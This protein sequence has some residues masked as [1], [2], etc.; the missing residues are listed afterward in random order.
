MWRSLLAG[1]CSTCLLAGCTGGE[2]SVRA[3][4]LV[5]CSEGSPDSFN[6]QI[7]TSGT[8]YDASAHTLYDRL[9]A[10]DPDTGT[11]LPALALSWTVSRDGTRWR[12]KLRP[13]VQFHHTAW[14]SPSRPFNADDIVFSFERQWRK[15][16]PYHR[17]SGGVY[18]YFENTGLHRLLAAIVKRSDDEVEFQLTESNAT[19]LSMLS[20]EF[21]SILSAEYAAQLL[22]AGKPEQLDQ[23][24]IGTGPFRLQRYD[25][26]AFIRYEAHPDYYAG[27][28]KVKRLVFAITPD[29]S[30]RLS[31]LR[32]GEC[33]VMSQPSPAHLTLIRQNPAL[34]L[35]SQPA[36][37]VSYWAFN[38]RRPPLN[39]ARV[40]QALA[41]A[42]NRSAILDAVYFGAGEIAKSPVPPTVPGHD[43]ELTDFRHD[44]ARA[45][46]LLA[47]AGY[48]DG[49]SLDV[50]AMPVSRPYN[51]NARKMAELIQDDLRQI[52]VNVRIV[53]YE[54]RDFLRRLRLGEH[55]SVLLGWSGDLNDADNFLSPLLTCAA[56]RAGSNRALWCDDMFDGLL[57]RA[58]TTR[59][60]DHRARLYS[61]ALH[62]F[63][64]QTPWLTL[65]HSTQYLAARQSIVGLRQSASGGV[66]FHQAERRK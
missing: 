48:A 21:A 24:P 62:I 39:D 47:E 29:V 30:L 27:A 11:A 34:R 26:G 12:F 28:A 37:N 8:A 46:E 53:S 19:F 32:A 14:F 1:F 5:Y 18:P 16:H 7:S 40:R 50:W 42:V 23:L 41:Y 57:A 33:D 44:P 51:P 61:E 36:L 6:P 52:G 38:T 45:R 4:G 60:P 20:M 65:A 43:A 64:Q 35:Y 63:K 9:I 13:D 3:T 31:R 10:L 54:W 2:Q 66:S 17:I 49:F 55:D 25:T 15:Q 58:R 22:Q 59:D 56:V